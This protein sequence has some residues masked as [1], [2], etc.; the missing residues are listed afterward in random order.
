M[1]SFPFT[2]QT[3]IVLLTD[4][5][6]KNK[7]SVFAYNLNVWKSPWFRGLIRGSAETNRP[8][9]YSGV[10]LINTKCM[11]TCILLLANKYDYFQYFAVKIKKLF[12]FWNISKV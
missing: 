11:M 9:S 7:I 2:F 3:R 5:T 8:N 10:K 12:N 4:A 1:L 6:L